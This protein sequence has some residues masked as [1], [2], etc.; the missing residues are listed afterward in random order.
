MPGPCWPSSAWAPRTC[1]GRVSSLSPGERTRADLALLRHSG[2]NL[3]VLDEPTNHL[4]LPAIIQ[5]EQALNSYDGT[6]VVI[7]HDRRFL[8]NLAL[9]RRLHLPAGRVTNEA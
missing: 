1:C 4:D 3:L 9:A 2:A 7:S 5:L 8:A 6:L